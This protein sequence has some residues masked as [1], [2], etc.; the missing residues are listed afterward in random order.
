MYLGFFPLDTFD[1]LDVFLGEDM[2]LLVDKS[3][4]D[5]CFVEVELLFVGLVLLL[6]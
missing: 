1:E 4:E 6:K 2:G 5:C 3:I